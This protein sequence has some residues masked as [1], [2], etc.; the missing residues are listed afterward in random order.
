M[1][2]KIII[3]LTSLLIAFSVMATTLEQCL[4]LAEE[5]YPLT[6]KYELIERTSELTVANIGKGWL[7]QITASAQVTLQNR[8]VALPEALTSMMETQGVAVKG[9]RKDQYR[10]GIDITQTVY[11]GGAIASG[12]EV[13]SRQAKVDAAA[14]EVDLYAVRQRVSELY[15]GI[16]LVDKRI[17]LIEDLVEL[18]MANEKK[19]SS[20][21]K[22]GTAAESDFSNIKAERL[23]SEQ[24]LTEMQSQRHLLLRLL[25]AF[26]GE[27]I[28]SVE[29]PDI[30]SLVGENNR[31]ELSLVDARINLLNA[32]QRQNDSA[33]RPRIALFASGY[34][35]YPG[36]D[37]YHDMF[38]RNWTLN[39]IVG[40][41]L[42]WNISA[43]YTRK[44]DNA[45]LNLQRMEL[46]NSR[47]VFLFN[48]KLEQISEDENIT[49][50]NNLL[51]TDREIV[52][53]RSS[54]RKAAES[55]LVH[56]IIDINDLLREINDEN[57]AK[58]Q[59]STHLIERL[60][61]L[62]NKK[63]TLNN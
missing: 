37:M 51:Q 17:E 50:Y 39:G 36:Y 29:M 28:G 4:R 60:K 24:R 14:N 22:R 30:P 41:K 10:L 26:C 62:W 3:T 5:N 45:K 2:K 59:M 20:M 15:F 13:A 48:N 1:T 16:L 8:V 11:D 32:V 52:D 49:R 33:L 54:V 27:E 44:N 40:A 55:K 23:S 53:L 19:L 43:F 42:T 56:G 18:L 6:K 21:V 35:G 46:E 61:L 38:S 25:S 63:L 12:R 57:A 58:V 7:P 47:D 34:Y 31:P 9:L